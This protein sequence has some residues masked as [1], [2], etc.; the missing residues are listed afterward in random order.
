[1]KRT[2]GILVAL[3]LLLAI[4]ATVATATDNLNDEGSQEANP[5]EPYAW[6]GTVKDLINAVAHVVGCL[7]GPS[8][9]AA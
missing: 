4:P 3:S 9:P 8:P 1:M 7:I 6:D 2:I 5:C